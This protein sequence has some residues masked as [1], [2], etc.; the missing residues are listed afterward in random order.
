MLN[1]KYS[2]N[3]NCLINIQFTLFAVCVA[4]HSLEFL[5]QPVY[6]CEQLFSSYGGQNEQGFLRWWSSVAVGYPA[7]RNAEGKLS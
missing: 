7:A 3:L 1:K 2:K 4:V 6:K 5:K